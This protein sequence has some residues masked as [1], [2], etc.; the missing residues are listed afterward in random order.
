[1]D[2]VRINNGEVLG[3]NL[4]DG[5]IINLMNKKNKE[6]ETKKIKKLKD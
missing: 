6:F 2:M 1:M 4:V 3:M 5:F